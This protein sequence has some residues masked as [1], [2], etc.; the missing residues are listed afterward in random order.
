MEDKIT[1][2]EN[3]NNMQEIIPTESI[4]SRTILQNSKIKVIQFAFA[5]GQELSEHTASVPAVIQILQGA[6]SFSVDDQ[7][8]KAGPGSWVYMPA[9]TKHTLIAETPMRMLL[10]MIQ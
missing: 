4:I 3:L 7:S 2:I 10:L 5:P 8:H 1:Y 9:N 6:C